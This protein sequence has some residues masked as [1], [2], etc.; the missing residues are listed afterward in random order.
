MADPWVLLGVCGL[1]CG[2]C[3]HYRASLPDGKHLLQE[4]LRQ[5]RKV[6]GYCCQGCR[7]DRLYMHPGCAQCTIRACAE[8]KGILHCG[9]CPDLPCDQL[10]AFQNDGRAHHGDVLAQ[11]EELTVKGVDRWLAEQHERWRCGCGAGFSWYEEV[12]HECRAPLASYG[13]DAKRRASHV[14]ADRVAAR[15]AP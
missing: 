12:C 9:L 1:Y 2:A 7:S 8:G 5:G 3:Y 13:R 15:R 14:A 4:A 10:R 6:E 11:L